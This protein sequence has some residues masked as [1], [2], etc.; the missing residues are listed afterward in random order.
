MYHEDVFFAGLEV[1]RPRTRASWFDP[2]DLN[3]GRDHDASLLLQDCV[4]RHVR[5]R[6]VVETEPTAVFCV[7]SERNEGVNGWEIGFVDWLLYMMYYFAFW[8][9]VGLTE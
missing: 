3:G 6:R 4:D 7:W 8:S 2:S 1:V 5:P 9:G